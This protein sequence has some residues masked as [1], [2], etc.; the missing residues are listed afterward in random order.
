MCRSLRAK[1]TFLVLALAATT[2]SLISTPQA[3]AACKR[4]CCPGD[5]PA[6]ITCCQAPGPTIVCPP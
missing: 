3:E 2:A 6:C 1:L 5:P 4:I